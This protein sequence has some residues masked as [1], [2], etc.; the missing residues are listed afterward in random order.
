MPP[1]RRSSSVDRWPAEPIEPMAKVSL[2]GLALAY[3]ISPFTSVTGRFLLTAT[4]SGALATSTTGVK[5]LTTL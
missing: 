1:A 3:A 4:A 2:P 5:S